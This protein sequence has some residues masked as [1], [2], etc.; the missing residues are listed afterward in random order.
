[1]SSLVYGGIY[2]LKNNYGMGSFLDTRNSGCE[3][4]WYCVS[5]SLSS[6]RHPGAGTALWQIVSATGAT[7]P[8]RNGDVVFLI[9]QFHPAAGYLDVRGGGCESNF[10]CVSTAV[11]WNRDNGSGK[12]KIEAD[13]AVTTIDLLTPIHF[14]NQWNGN[15]GY[16]DVRAGGCESNMYCVSTSHNRI[17]DGQSTFWAF[18]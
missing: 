8:V 15:G 16:L 13:P 7:G 14:H 9:N 18:L 1:M 10:L 11:T 17:R 6:D 2:Y 5:T 4:T 3:G 12:W